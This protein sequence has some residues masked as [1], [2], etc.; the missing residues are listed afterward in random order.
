[1]VQA[2]DPVEILLPGVPEGELRHVRRIVQF[3]RLLMD[4]AGSARAGAVALGLEQA[5]SE[6]EAQDRRRVEEA[7][8]DLLRHHLAALATSDT[9]LEWGKPGLDH[10]S[11]WRVLDEFRDELPWLAS[12]PEP[13]ERPVSVLR[14]LIDSHEKLAMHGSDLLVWKARVARFAEG[15]RAAEALL[16]LNMD[17]CIAQPSSDRATLRLLL[18]VLAEC[19]LDRGAVREARVALQEKS[20]LLDGDPRLRQLYSWT[21]LCLGDYAGAKSAIVG[22]A[23]GSSSLPAPLVELRSRRPE[24]LPCLAGR[25]AADG[26]GSALV[27][28]AVATLRGRGEFGAA[29]LAVFRLRAGGEAELLHLDAAPGL[30]QGV[31]AWL[32]DRDGA[33]VV[34]GQ[35]EH[36]LVVSARAVVVHRNGEPP[37]QEALGRARTLVLALVPVLDHEGEVAGWLHVESEHHLL[38]SLAVLT[39]RAATWRAA[40]LGPETRA[41]E[42]DGNLPSGVWTL[43]DGPSRA[44][45]GAVFERLVAEL[46]IK[47]A[48]RRWFGFAVEGRE[49]RLLASGGEG[50][51]L[52]TDITGRGRAL[53]RALATSSAVGFENPDPRLSIDPNAASGVV[54]PLSAG[55]VLCGLL[56]IESSRRKDFREA[57]QD[58]FT[59][60]TERGGLEL[61]LAQFVT[62]HA[63][64]FGDE[65][66]LDVGRAEFSGFA[67]DFLTAARSRSPVVLAGPAGVGKTVLAR[68]L[69]FESRTGDA[70][71]R[72]L[73]CGSLPADTNLEDWIGPDR[74]GSLILKDIE[75]LPAGAQAQLLR[76]L[77]GEVGSAAVDG[78]GPRILATTRI[79]VR[80][81]TDDGRLRDDLSHRLDRLQ[82]RLSALRDRR[83]DIPPLVAC[84]TRRFA[85]QEALPVP[86]LEDDAL[87]LLWRQPWDGNVRELESFLYKIVLFCRRGHVRAPQ[88][89]GPTQVLEIAHR[90]SLPVVERLPSRHPSRSDLLAALRVTRK[91]GGRLNKTRAALYLGWDPDTLV[92]RMQD[93]SI[94]DDLA[95][96]RGQVPVH[97]EPADPPGQS[98]G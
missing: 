42:P 69:H 28:E 64:H 90:F 50:A 84:L 31:T 94:G 48:Q 89:V 79:G 98:G 54:L 53:T 70:P 75:R 46:G 25:A 47:T 39:E 30:R 66:W 96:D 65:V 11:A 60:V 14:R 27:P 52:S 18:A 93:E 56:A 6:F 41:R 19:L 40:I 43:A 72:V 92:A 86:A 74:G 61:R 82:F 32:R 78:A 35:C 13:A 17:A 58:R 91:P 85:R 55:G 49:L 88:V 67:R 36:E 10:A 44:A 83:E 62:W 57:D 51:G 4:D 29:V 20:V 77:E 33:C 1:M 9:F 37:I 45:C 95:E 7:L 2:P 16:R 21:L 76:I 63:E 59:R 24:W 80:P 38:P 81:A 23:Q 8:N 87:A 12:L 71:L 3:L 5:R 15:P 26:R 97:S 68:W 73:D 34:R 22:L